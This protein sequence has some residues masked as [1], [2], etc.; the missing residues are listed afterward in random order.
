MQ[1]RDDILQTVIDKQQIA[2]V[3]SNWAFYRDRREWDN[4]KDCFTPDGTMVTLFYTGPIGGFLEYVK[5][6]AES[7]HLIAN[8]QITINKNKAICESNTLFS[9]RI[10]IDNMDADMTVFC[11]VFDFFEKG[12]DEIWRINK[13]VVD[14][15]KDRIDPI[16]L[17]G[18]FWY[19]LYPKKKLDNYP[20]AC[21]HFCYLIESK[22]KIDPEKLKTV[23][24]KDSEAEANLIKEVAQWL[25]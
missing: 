13:R 8:T 21:K 2:E 11:R 17:R 5:K 22:V 14:Y 19:L 1:N 12:N 23:I 3:V 24:T 20:A 25:A 18:L 10:R 4:L 16:G 9:G 7:K 6:M 15:E